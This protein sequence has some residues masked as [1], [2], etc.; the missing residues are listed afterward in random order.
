MSRVSHKDTPARA[1]P[2]TCMSDYGQRSLHEP[3]R[4]STSS[5]IEVASA[6]GV[7]ACSLLPVDAAAPR[8]HYCRGLAAKLEGLAGA[9]RRWAAVV[10]LRYSFRCWRCFD[11]RVPC[12][13]LDATMASCCTHTTTCPAVPSTTEDNSTLTR[14]HNPV[15]VCVCVCVCAWIIYIPAPAVSPEAFVYVCVSQSL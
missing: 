9:C 11:W 12:L 10:L 15:C 7:R 6:P 5:E 4:V 14:L 13:R 3:V 2:A 8:N 1:R